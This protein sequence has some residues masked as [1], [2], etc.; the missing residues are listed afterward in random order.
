MLYLSELI[1]KRVVDRQGNGVARIRDLVAELV[2][3]DENAPE[4]ALLDDEGQPI[5]RDVPVVKGVLAR[6][7]RRR[8]PF[9]IPIKQIQSLGRDGARIFSSRLDVQPF[10]RREGE[11]LLARDLWDKQIIDLLRRRVVRVNDIVIAASATAAVADSED[12]GAHRWWVRGVDVGMGSLLRRI[13]IDR[14]VGSIVKK[15]I[16]PR[17][18]RWQHVDVFGSNVPGGVP[19]GHKKLANLHPV[20]IARITD[21]LSY[22]QGAEIISSLDDT[23]AADTLEEIEIDR[24]TDIIDEI[25]EERAA[26]IIEEMAPDEATDLLSELPEE[27]AGALLKEMDDED[28]SEVRQLMRYKENSAGGIMTTDFVCATPNM[29]VS[30]VIEANKP[31]FLSADLIYYIYVVKADDD[32]TLVG[33]IT[34]RD[35]LVHDGDRQIADFMLTDLL[36]VRPGEDRR[37]VA[38]KMAEYNLLALPVVDAKN[39]LVGVVTVDDALDALLPEGWKKRFPRIFS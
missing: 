36:M 12:A 37:E 1:G 16:Q 5:E 29:T 27:R 3:P 28:A 18:V 31:V 2:A 19:L 4:E 9:F 13:H 8:Q 23:L 24:Q 10:E 30:E 20:E 32:D 39:T 15:A 25:P 11:L 33:L 35:L 38:R 22:R 6:T 26:D 34:V 17:I 14:P 21:S 7:G